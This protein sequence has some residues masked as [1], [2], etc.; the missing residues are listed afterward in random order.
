MYL[1]VPRDNSRRGSSTVKEPHTR[2]VVSPKGFGSPCFYG[3]DRRPLTLRVPSQP[4][5]TPT[6]MTTKDNVGPG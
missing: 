4:P 3:W 1:R 6:T 5:D 2:V